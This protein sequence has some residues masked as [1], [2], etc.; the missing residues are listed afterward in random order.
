MEQ[1]KIDRKKIVCFWNSLARTAAIPVVLFTAWLMSGITEKAVSGN[2]LLVIKM[3]LFLLTLFI[4]SGV[5]QAAADVMIRRQQAKAMN[6]CRT[7]FLEMVLHNPLYRLCG[8]DYGELNENLNDDLTAWAKYYMKG[9]PAMVSGAVGVIGY[10]GYLIYRSPVAAGT[11]LI[12]S[13]LQLLPPLVVK[14]YMEINY[15]QCRELEAKITDHIAEAVSGF[16]TIKLYGLQ[17]WWMTK[18]CGMQKDYLHV[19]NRAETS[20]AVQR[21][22]YRLLDHIL[23][24]GTYAI[25]GMYVLSGYLDLDTAIVG[26]VLSGS[27]F[28]AVRQI[29]HEIPEAAVSKQAQKRLN[30]W[31]FVEEREKE[32]EEES[33]EKNEEGN[34]YSI[35][36]RMTADD[37]I[38]V[39]NLC[40]GYGETKIFDGFS[41]CFRHEA[42]YLLTG[43]N[44]TGKTTFLNLLGG[45]YRPVDGRILYGGKVSD[46][47]ENLIS[48]VLQED[49]VFDFDVRTLFAMLDGKAQRI[50]FSIANYLGLPEEVMDDVPITSLSGGER[51]KVFLAVGLAADSKWLFLDEPTNHLDRQGKEALVTLLRKRKGIFMV[52]HDPV[53]YQA[54][55]SVLRLE[56]GRILR[57]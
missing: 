37:N 44:G 22:L 45:L 50:A 2:V 38:K 20:A 49:P 17:Q 32:R 1:D 19:G 24:Y 3:S 4:V 39:E 15:D 31:K 57:I 40:Y 6:E 34:G 29:F 46:K 33:E 30:R 35:Q 43:D 48:Y 5:F 16:E 42:N 21:T 53:F 9:I 12:I 56:K 23:K 25:L 10:M 47:K 51:K 18:M 52:S 41:D 54:A 11:I 55:D 7:A 28:A 14:R 8:A 13:L 27:L 36:N 26:I